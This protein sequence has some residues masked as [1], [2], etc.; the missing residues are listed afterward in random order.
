MGSGSDPLGSVPLDVLGDVCL[1]Y[2]LEA[3]GFSSSVLTHTAL[4]CVCSLVSVEK[5]FT[6]MFNPFHRLFECLF[7]FA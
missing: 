2:R 1:L 7:G 5:A 6:D 3:P 4:K